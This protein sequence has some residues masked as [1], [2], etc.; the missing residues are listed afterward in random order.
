MEELLTQFPT[1]DANIPEYR[2]FIYQPERISIN[3]RQYITGVAPTALQFL[4]SDYYY[5]FTT[6]LRS[7]L[8]GVKSLELIR[9]SIPNAVPSVPND[10]ACFYYYRIPA[11]PVTFLPNYAAL[12]AANIHMVRLLPMPPYNPDNYTNP[13][14][15]GWNTTFDDYQS[16]V[17]ALNLAAQN[18]PNAAALAGF[19]IANDIEFYYDATRNKIGFR[20]LNFEQPVA[21]NEPQFYY[22][23]VGYKDPNLTT[24]Q[25]AVRAAL[26][27]PNGVLFPTNGNYT[28]NKRLGFLWDGLYTLPATPPIPPAAPST[29][30]AILASRTAPY[31]NYN[32]A[33]NPL[34]PNY[35]AETYADL[36]NTANIFVYCDIV[37]G[38]T[39]DTNSDE[40]LLAVVPTNASN[41]GVIFG[42]SKMLVPLTKVSQ[43]ISQITIT[44]RTDT[45]SPFYLPKSAYI[46]LELKFYY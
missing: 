31:P 22:L 36:V 45:G 10:E 3:S 18:D 1:K 19:Y 11:D 12:T 13:D 6:T 16:I 8:L 28:L 23:P 14:D 41:L 15:Y 33:W 17:D 39:Q 29:G 9:A 7:P 21:P 30:W 25:D 27:D 32:G 44:L 40:R 38:S 4:D 37:G 43:T 20:G 2:S 35:T 46:N 26:S 24:F 34:L 42:E 5:T